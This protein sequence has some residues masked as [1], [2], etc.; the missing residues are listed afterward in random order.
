MDSRIE[1]HFR[2]FLKARVLGTFEFLF[3][4]TNID[5]IY[6]AYDGSIVKYLLSAWGSNSICN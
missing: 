3:H 5:A 2:T 4:L 1:L 6:A